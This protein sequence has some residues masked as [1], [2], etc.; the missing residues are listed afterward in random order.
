[1]RKGF[2]L[3]LLLAL[4]AMPCLAAAE[5]A[6]TAETQ[7]AEVQAA[8]SEPL[9]LFDARYYFEHR[10][11]QRLFYA[12]PEETMAELSGGGLYGRWNT[13]V[14]EIGFA[15]TYDAG[16][17]ETRDMSRDGIRVLMLSMPEPEK[18]LLCYRI[19]L[20]WDAGT[21]NAGY[22]TAEYDKVEGFFDEGC[23]ICG[24]TADGSHHYY[25]EG[26]ILPDS[27]DPEYEKALSAEADAV[28]ELMRKSI[29]AAEGKD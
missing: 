26:S 23:L 14:T 11:L 5:E 21:G 25:L 1:M 28:L 27:R 19:Y 9:T 22:Y 8:E 15:V 10:L 24:W 20:C 13:Y 12:A 16:Q 2:I 7:A 3:L 18:T 29:P 17:F 4:A 6:G